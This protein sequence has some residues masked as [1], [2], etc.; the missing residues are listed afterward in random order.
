MAFVINCK[1]Y[2]NLFQLGK[3]RRE[4]ARMKDTLG[5]RYISPKKKMQT[6]RRTNEEIPEKKFPCHSTG[7]FV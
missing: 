4:L 2:T 1:E 6:V 3:W 5:A 7:H